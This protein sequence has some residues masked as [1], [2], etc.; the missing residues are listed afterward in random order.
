MAD[1]TDANGVKWSV[2]RRWGFRYWNP[3]DDSDDVSGDLLIIL[4]QWVVM[5]PIWFVAKWF[6]VA[7]VV[8]IERNGTVVREVNVRGWRRSERRI[9]EFA[10]SAFEGTLD[11]QIAA[12]LPA[13]PPSDMKVAADAWS[14]LSLESRATLWRMHNT[15]G[16]RR[17]PGRRL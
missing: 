2:Y 9:Q 8:V 5:A 1:V 16:L 11:A 17:Q 3:L 13:S 4:V 6:G 15:G 12:E 14:N 10:R 7:W